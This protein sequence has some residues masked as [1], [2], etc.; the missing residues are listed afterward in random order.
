MLVALRS[1]LAWVASCVNTSDALR[2][3]EIGHEAVAKLHTNLVSIRK[4]HALS[5]KSI[6]PVE[7]AMQC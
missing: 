4:A 2:S 6:G 5:K 7:V 3:K 1:K